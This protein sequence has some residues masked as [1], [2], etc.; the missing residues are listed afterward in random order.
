MNVD[1]SSE[2]ATIAAGGSVVTSAPLLVNTLTN[3]ADS[4]TADGSPT[5]GST[6]GIGV[7]LA[8]NAAH[9]IDPGEH[10]RIGHGARD[11]RRRRK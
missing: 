11:Q 1:L 5:D 2:T 7:A 10:R 8:I 4:A 3:L 6:V 9:P